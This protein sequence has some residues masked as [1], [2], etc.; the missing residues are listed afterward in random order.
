MEPRSYLICAEAGSTNPT[1]AGEDPYSDL[2]V[3]IIANSRDAGSPKPSRSYCARVWAWPF[4]VVAA[5]GHA[6]GVVLKLIFI[7]V[8]L[9]LYSLLLMPGFLRMIVYYFFS[10]NVVRGI[11]YGPKP[12][13]R[14]DLYFPPDARNGVTYPVVI[15]ITGGAWTIGYKAW[16][17]LLAR[18]LSEG[19]VL[20]ACLDYRNFPQGDALDMLEDVNTG[21]SWVLSRIHRFGGDPDGVTLVG[22]SAGG[23]LAGL[24][25]IKQAEQAARGYPC[26][27]ATPA[28]SPACL[29]AFVGVS[30]AFDLEA[31][32]QHRGGHFR[33]LLD[34][35]LALDDG[36]EEA[37][38]AAGGGGGASEAEECSGGGK[39]A[40]GG[41][42]D[43]QIAAAAA[44]AGGP[45]PQPQIGDG[46]VAATPAASLGGQARLPERRRR[47][48]RQSRQQPRQKRPAYESL[49]PLQAARRLPPGA[50]ELL[51]RVLL[52]HGTADKT[53]PAEGSARLSE[54]LQT[55]GAPCVRCCL[56]P[57][58]THTAFLLEDPMRGG[59]DL[60]SDTV[61]GAALREGR[62]P[63]ADLEEGGAGGADGGVGEGDGGRRVYGS[64]CP[65]FLCNMAGWVCPF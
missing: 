28:W 1:S 15:Y 39:A 22:Q 23:H 42:G 61:L 11:V 54:A 45:A 60:L 31:L 63:G 53:V 44:A 19:G 47:Q 3:P 43:G 29:R 14:L 35:I 18:R 46:A 64:L 49:S 6:I 36:G 38:A 27:G 52:I 58:K 34:R 62:G 16:G 17:A 9:M 20:V 12:R 41:S 13:Q 55:S 4:N 59:T 5:I 33:G 65:A 30:G 37:V 7:V 10:K 32:A 48:P 57:G 40:G 50:A 56:V 24:A 2:R 51:P 8:C 25:L 21:I 26:L